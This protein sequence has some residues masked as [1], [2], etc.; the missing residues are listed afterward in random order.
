VSATGTRT[1]DVRNLPAGMEGFRG[2]WAQKD[3][4]FSRRGGGFVLYERPASAARIGFTVRTDRSRNPFST[5]ARVKW[6]VNYVDP[7]N[8][9]LIELASDYLY[10]TEVVNGNRRELPRVA[11][12]MPSG[13]D[14]L[15]ISVEVSPNRVVH[16]Y[17]AGAGWTVLDS[18]DVQVPDGGRFGFYLPATETLEV[19]NFRYDP[20]VT[21]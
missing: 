20:A 15:N 16:Q 4:W 3:T 14:V 11:Y 9:A 1:I 19:T 2:G 10:R 5:G 12:K 7:R 17:N 8:H 6:V 21:R 13:G 18:W